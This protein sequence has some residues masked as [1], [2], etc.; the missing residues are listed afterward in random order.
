MTP[1]KDDYIA[2]NLEAYDALA[3]EFNEKINTRKIQQGHIVKKFSKFLKIN[4]LVETNILELGPA[5]GYTTK[6]LSESG[7]IVDALEFSSELSQFCKRNAPLANVIND[8]FLTYDFK[9]KK[10][11]GI[12]AVAFI[13][14]FP[15]NITKQVLSKIHSLLDINGIAYI[16]TTLHTM[17]NQGFETKSNFNKQNIRFRRRFTEVELK[18]ELAEAGFKIIKKEIV[19]DIEVDN[20]KWIDFIVRR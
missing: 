19:D 20:K 12:L 11:M 15:K 9:E 7:Y 8:E 5:A 17:S 16:S 6:L 18:T 4:G 2:I 13:H 10:Y 14:L 3:G 1:S